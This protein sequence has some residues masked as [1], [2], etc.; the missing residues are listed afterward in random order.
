MNNQTYLFVVLYYL[1]THTQ[2]DKYKPIRTELSLFSLL[3]KLLIL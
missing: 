2:K 3:L 1:H